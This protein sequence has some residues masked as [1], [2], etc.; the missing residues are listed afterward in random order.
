MSWHRN[1]FHLWSFRALS[2]SPRRIGL[3]L[4][5][6]IRLG[7]RYT[8]LAHHTR[9]YIA[10]ARNYSRKSHKMQNLRQHKTNSSKS[11][12]CG[13]LFGYFDKPNYPQQTK[14][15]VFEATLKSRRT[16]NYCNI[17]P[18]KASFVKCF[19]S[20][21]SLTLS[22]FVSRILCISTNLEM[23]QFVQ[24]NLATLSR[25]KR[26]ISSSFLR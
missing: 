7:A 22:L 19:V 6:R 26:H 17:I 5:S 20:S 18:Q 2:T 13:H 21:Q 15:W 14:I 25:F 24:H 4:F 8:S 10:R 9:A 23:H 16:P 11:V 12:C 1:R 3:P